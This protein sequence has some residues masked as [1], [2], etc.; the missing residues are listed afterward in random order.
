MSNGSNNSGLVVDGLRKNFGGISVFRD[1]S[2]A[3]GFGDTLG[4][5]GPNGAGKT[6]L[7]NLISGQL[8]PT[9]GRVLVGGRDLA[10][11]S[12]PGR[13]RMG[14]VRSFQQTSVF[15]RATV[16]ENIHRGSLFS[17][18]LA[19]AGLTVVG[20]L[21]EEL[22]LSDLID[23]TAETLPYGVQKITGLLMVVA[24]SPQIMLLD[25]PAAGLEKTERLMV[26]T[27]VKHAQQALRCGVL[28]VEHDMDLVR[29]ICD[30]AIVLNDGAILAHGAP[31]MVLSRADV[32]A[33]YIGNDS[34]EAER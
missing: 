11:V 9:A 22:H 30:D 13:S 26:D 8:P 33:A 10:G 15:G 17:G 6:T 27:I 28:I 21:V 31:D 5:I 29:R 3:L 7:I 20:E 34:E 1:V 19:G 16:R 2:F 25:E 4:V 32:I 14:L 23:Q 12:F 18:R 24:T